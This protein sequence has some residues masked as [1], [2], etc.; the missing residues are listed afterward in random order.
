MERFPYLKQRALFGLPGIAHLWQE[1]QNLTD[2]LFETYTLQKLKITHPE[3]WEFCYQQL[4]D[5][6]GLTP[7]SQNTELNNTVNT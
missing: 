5:F 1:I 2:H 7:T 4:Y 3:D 6:L